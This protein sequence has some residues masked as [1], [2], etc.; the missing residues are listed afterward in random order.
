MR[1]YRWAIRVS[2]G[3]GGVVQFIDRF[4]LDDVSA[5]VWWPA[6]L[7]A[8]I[9][10]VLTFPLGNRAVLD[11][12]AEAATRA[13]ALTTTQ[14]RD[15]FDQ[16]RTT[17]L[18][19]EVR[20]G[21][22][23]TTTALLDL[24]AGDPE[25]SAAR[26]WSPQFT[27]WATSVPDEASGQLGS[28]EANNDD[29]LQA[30]TD[31][32]AFS[33]VTD[34]LPT[35]G[36]G[37]TVFHSYVR[38]GGIAGGEYIADFEARDAVLLADVHRQ[39]LG[40]RIVG[41][42]ATLLLLG[43]AIASMREP[44][45]RIG[46]NVPFYTESVP[47]GMAVVELDRAVELDQADERVHDRISGLQERLDESERSRLKAEAQLQQALTALGSGAR[48]ITRPPA[49]AADEAA[50][51]ART[52]RRGEQ[53]K[54]TAAPTPAPAPRPAAQQARPAAAKQ[55][56][57]PQRTSTPQ[58]KPAQRPAAATP[59]E[60]AARATQPEDPGAKHIAKPAATKVP[61]PPVTTQQPAAKAPPA[62]PKR[63]TSKRAPTEPVT[64][65]SDEVAVTAAGAAD[66]PEVVVLP[67]PE[68]EKVNAGRGASSDADVLDVLN[69]LVP[70]NEHPRSAEEPGDLRARL[71]RTAALKKPGSRE[72]QEQRG[73]AEGPSQQ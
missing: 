70:E 57:V 12:R 65:S 73:A 52:P 6:T 28:G 10:F 26:V 31:Q 36:P 4:T 38:L 1:R 72:R 66:R 15:P 34:R 42:I 45:A 30:A 24:F 69:R 32:G 64:V 21:N 22:T 40:Y 67:E 50:P 62:P 47:A 37:P 3:R 2:V 19:A 49:Q 39:W 17:S 58:P 33:L 54:P 46:T 63:K 43:F 11:A 5:K 44:R 14:I 9:A 35:G 55:H 18:Q 8:L 48:G 56:P 25:W 61:P 29:D 13:A 23:A 41:V 20:A 51:P 68:K 27:L 59:A 53:P 60:P 16:T 71:A 7:V